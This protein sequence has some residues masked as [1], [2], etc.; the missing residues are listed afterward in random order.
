M[1]GVA[2]RAFWPTMTFLKPFPA[3]I[4]VRFSFS[5]RVKK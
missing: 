5:F 3:E 4:R 2:M 1:A